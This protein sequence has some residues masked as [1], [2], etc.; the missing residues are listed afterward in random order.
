MQKTFIK[1]T[2]AVMT[3]GI[4]LILG[5]N[6]IFTLRSL[7]S[8]QYNTFR[9]KIK[10]VVHTLENNQM[11]LSLMNENLDRDY[12]T[13]ARAAAYV[14]DR[15]GD[16]SM[17]VSEMQ[18]LAKLLDVDELHVIDE[19]GIIESG[20]VSGYIGMDMKDDKQTRE[21][22]SLLGNEDENAYLIQE[23]QPNAAEKKMMQYVG[24]T[25]KGKKGIVQV[26]FAPTRQMEAESRNSYRYIFSQFP[27][28]VGEELYAIDVTE[29]KMVGHSGG[30]NLKYKGECY[31]INHL[32]D[33][34]EGAYKKGQNGE[35]M[36]VVSELYDDV[37]ICA[38]VPGTALFEETKKDFLNTLLYFLIVE[39][40]VIILLNFL[41]KKKVINGIHHII[42]ALSRITRG[43]L[44]ITVSESGNQEFVELS[45]GINAMVESII[46]IS[47]RISAIIEISGV[48]LAAF[49]YEMGSERVFITSRLRELLQI[50]DEEAE[51][52]CGDSEEFDQYIR[53]IT[54]HPVEEEEDVYQINDQKYVRIYMSESEDGYLGVITDVTGTVM[55]KRQMKYENTHDPLTR[56]YKF[57]YFKRRAEEVLN[58]MPFGKIGAVVMLDLD[59]FKSINDTYGHDMGDVYLQSFAHALQSLS[60]EH[61]IPARRSGDE[62]C[63]MIHDCDDKAEIVGYLEELYRFL[64][65]HP[66]ALS[67]VDHKVIA[68]SAGFAVAEA[69]DVDI[70]ALLS[71][72][73]EAL[74]EMKRG[75]KGHYIEYKN[76]PQG[77]AH[78]EMA[79]GNAME[80]PHDSYGDEEGH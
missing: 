12:L 57:P 16:I 6:F 37:L 40:G 10:Q 64:E 20:S 60:Q 15:Q 14:L 48:P 80:E 27:T 9:T 43:N 29:E 1:Y 65:N 2:L 30:M 22:L 61:V 28:D 33:C 67:D 32:L 39:A 44:N 47:D 3:A 75:V 18:Y 31:Q 52:I 53:R 7:E 35:R 49:E 5:I 34:A 73:D 71:R 42:D 72:A 70:P 51:R 66:V 74:Y 58:G 17:D 78:E 68:A 69:G 24:V 19:K 38:A 41:V 45:N 21:F 4:M 77:F 11:E 62:F 26:G 50:P 54:E 79:S 36:Y 13:R 25:R 55:E 76:E 56:L 23:A 59:Y 46:S 63:M 8:A